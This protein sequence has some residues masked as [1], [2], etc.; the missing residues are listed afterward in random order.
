MKPLLDLHSEFCN[1]QI[2]FKENKPRTITWFKEIIGYFVKQTGVNEISQIN[3]QLIENWLMAGRLELN[4]SAKTVRNRFIAV[5]LFL[6]WCVKK[7]HLIENP[8]SEVPT[9]KLGKTP[10]PKHLTREEADRLLDWARCYPYFKTYEKPRAVAIIATFLFTGIRLKE[11]MNLKI[12]HVNLTENILIVRQGKGG[13]DR[14]IPI[15]EQLK[16]YLTDYLTM[17]PKINTESVYFFVSLKNKGQMSDMVVKRLFEKLKSKSGI[18]FYPH[19]LRHTFAVLMLEAGCNLFSVS[20]LL[21]HSDIKTTTIYLSATVS[22]LQD[23][24][25]KYPLQ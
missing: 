5:N 25:S 10:I 11:L 2:V 7:G 14:M 21:G 6:K 16:G 8:A 15:H 18:H 9:P 13:K 24:I 22:H 17:R 19:L 3:S 23:Q 20:R 1:Y 12:D 4:W